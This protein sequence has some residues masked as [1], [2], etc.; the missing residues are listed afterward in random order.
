MSGIVGILNVDGAPV[1]R[2]LLQ[3]MTDGMAYR[4]PDAQV[5]W[6][7][8]HVGFGHAML[9]TTVDAQ[10]EWQPVSLDGHVWMTAD[11]RVDGRTDLIRKLA[12]HGRGNLGTATDAELILHAYHVWGQECLAHLLGDFAF[13]IWDGRV[14]RL[15]C[16]RDQLGVK[17]LYYAQRADCLLFSNT[18]NCLRLHPAVS[19]AL[20]EHAIG[21]FLLFGYNQEPAT[22]TFADI[23]RLPAAHSF[24]WSDGALRLTRYWTLPLDGPIRYPKAGDYVEHFQELL[25]TAVADRLRTTRI[26]VSMSG[27]LDSTAVAA[28]AHELL[29]RQTLPFDL[30]AYTVVYDRLI[31]DEERHY[32]GLVAKGLGVPIHY[33]PADDYGLYERWDQPELQTPEPSATPLSAVALDQLRTAAAY[34]RVMLG[35][36]GGDVGFFPSFSCFFDLIK[37]CRLGPLL[38][39]IGRH[40]ISY[41]RLPPTYTR[42][43]LKRWLGVQPRRPA[44]PAWLNPTFAARYDLPARWAQVYEESAP[45]HPLRPE[46]YHALTAPCWPSNFELYDPGATLLPLEFRQ[47]FFDLRLLTYLLALPSIPWCADKELL[48]IAMCGRLPEPVR[49]RPKVPLAGDPLH[50]LVTQSDP[51]VFPP[52]D[53]IEP[54]VDTAVLGNVIGDRDKF[55][56]ETSYLITLPFNLAY[57]MH[58]LA[59][60]QEKEKGAQPHEPRR[61]AQHTTRCPHTETTEV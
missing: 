35:G 56:P 8:H 42:A 32:A 17:P 47:P 61:R 18:L 40:L 5:V 49:R 33:L 38:T 58:H 4:G 36:E 59:S 15:F 12:T 54:F 9:R 23:Q 29:S 45:A 27:G 37:D 25:C 60:C 26:G 30:R 51:S 34:S 13:G 39:Y 21:D 24:T 7:D 48:R 11:A 28:T 22:T 6:A 50:L 55:E 52:T 46:A 53:R 20:N 43:Q 57:W 3:R 2:R 16:A 44:Y 1:N 31:P 10:Q 14:R 19:D 41:R